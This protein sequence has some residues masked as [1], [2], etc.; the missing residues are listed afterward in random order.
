MKSAIGSWKEKTNLGA[1][2]TCFQ[3]LH[4]ECGIS[5]GDNYISACVVWVYLRVTTAKLNLGAG[6]V[7][8]A[9]D[10]GTALS[11]QFMYISGRVL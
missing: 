10:P 5:G 8:T 7:Q 4:V 3:T 11:I 6:W 9:T 2:C 1:A